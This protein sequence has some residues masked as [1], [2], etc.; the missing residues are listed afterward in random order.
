MKLTRRLTDRLAVVR[1][2]T[3]RLTGPLKRVY[4]TLD[5][6]VL[7]SYKTSDGYITYLELFLARVLFASRARQRVVWAEFNEELAV[8][9]GEFAN[10]PRDVTGALVT[11]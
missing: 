3:R 11:S 7:S 6:N 2:F 8:N 9:L 1:K 4:R 5:L 10:P